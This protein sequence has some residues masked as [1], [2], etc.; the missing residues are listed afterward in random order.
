M[1]VTFDQAEGPEETLR[2]LRIIHQQF[3]EEIL[4]GAGTVMT[5]G[6]VK[7][8]AAAGAGYII[9]PNTDR[10]VIETTKELGLISIPGAFTPTEAATAYAWGADVVK[11]FPAGLLG[12]AYI[13][14]LTGPLPHIPFMAV[15]GIDAQNMNDFLR[16]GAVGVGVGGNLVDKKRIAAGKF[17][18]ITDLALQYKAL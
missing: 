3:P 6:Q 16:A 9:S 10:A 7:A 2:S 13:K 17:Q 1:E 11:L 5:A 4:L 15:G 18:E 8:A 12:P 14:A